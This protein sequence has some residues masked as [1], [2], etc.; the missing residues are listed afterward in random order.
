MAATM[1]A[2]RFNRTGDLAALTLTDVPMPTPAV[3][4]AL[5]K[6]HASGLNPSDV[7]N[8]LG[9]FPYTTL[10]RTPGRDFAGTVVSG[11]AEWIGKAVWGTGRSLGFTRDG[12]H[13]EYL[14]LPIT[15]LTPKPE[16]LSFAQAASCGVPY[17]TAR[18][19]LERSGVGAGTQILIIG[20]GGAVGQA[21]LTMA[22]ARGANILAG[23]RR[24]EQAQAFISAGTS[25]I[26][27]G[28][29]ETLAQRVNEHFPNGPEVVFDTT[30]LWLEPAVKVLATFG[31]IAVIAAPVDGFT[32]LPV[33]DLY[34]RGGSIVGVNSLLYDVQDCA[35]LL[36]LIREEFD[37]GRLSH[38]KINHTIPFTHALESYEKVHQGYSEKIVLAMMK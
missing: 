2:L 7:K 31:R 18:D 36:A 14:T 11:S 1:K 29:P 37:S 30:G 25:A 8:I 5:I 26:V 4:E 20:A 34:R 17:I 33:L 12:S 13:A 23:V 21:A 27:L 15:A 16:S 32:R 38:P 3:G 28:E 6:I 19:A 24:T 9:R 22:Q 35:S 10:P